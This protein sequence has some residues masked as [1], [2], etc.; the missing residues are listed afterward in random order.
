WVIVEI[1]KR[2]ED[3]QLSI[4][5]SLLSGYAAFVPADAIGASGVLAAVTTGIFVGVRGPSIIPARVRLQG[6]Y[7]WDVLDFLLNASLFV[8]VG[9]QLRTI[10]DGLDGSWST[11]WP[12][13]SG[14]ARTPSSGCAR[15]TSTGS[16][17]SRPAPGPSRTTA[18][19]TGRSP[20]SACCSR[21]WAPSAPRSCACAATARSPTR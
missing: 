19:R 2:I 18:T 8:L 1:R 12:T 13:R 7:V 10:V 9:L 6:F 17:G 5:I 11:L 15:C 3:A 20:T 16:A 4:T 21:C 14:R